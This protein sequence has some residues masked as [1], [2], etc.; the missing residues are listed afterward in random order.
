MVEK[1]DSLVFEVE[2]AV[3][4]VLDS[5]VEASCLYAFTIFLIL[6]IGL[7]VPA[8]FES[9]SDMDR[10]S[11][12]E[13]VAARIRTTLS[14]IDKKSAMDRNL[15]GVRVIASV[16]DKE[17]ESV[18]V[19]E[20]IRVTL[21]VRYT[22]SERVR[23]AARI[24]VTESDKAKESDKDFGTFLSC[25]ILSEIDRESDKDAVFAD[26]TLNMSVIM[27]VSA[28][29]RTDAWILVTASVMD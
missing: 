20:K 9:L 27:I 14:D 13:R 3:S 25:V 16:I 12:K 10:E 24:R 22:I 1:Y 8:Y 18:I 6:D 7:L 29:E 11:D 19:V 21:S 17:S 28:R 23:V 2:S 26:M 15:A 5:E 4:D